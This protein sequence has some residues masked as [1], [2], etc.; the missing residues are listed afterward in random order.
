M[1]CDGCVGLCNE[2]IE[3][4]NVVAL[5]RADQAAGDP[6]LPTLTVFLQGRS[7]Q[8]LRDYTDRAQA[9]LKRSAKS[10]HHAGFHL[11]DH[12]RD[13][14]LPLPVP[15][16]L[17]GKSKTEITKLRDSLATSLAQGEQ[18]LAAARAVL[19]ERG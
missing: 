5:L 17:D 2:V 6:G 10:L 8:Q 16:A 19:A 9:T 18:V 15:D 7:T 4:E 12:P 14:D 13:P 1:I 11:G 3:H